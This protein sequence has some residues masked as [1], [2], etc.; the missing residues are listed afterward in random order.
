MGEAWGECVAAVSGCEEAWGEC[1]CLA[2]GVCNSAYC[3]AIDELP[4]E[5][6]DVVDGPVGHVRWVGGCSPDGFPTTTLTFGLDEPSCVSTASGPSLEITFPG[7]VPDSRNVGDE[8]VF[9]ENIELPQVESWFD[10]NGNGIS[11]DEPISGGVIRLVGPNT[12]RYEL[13]H[14]GLLV[15][16]EFSEVTPCPSQPPC[17]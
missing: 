13:F 2:G 1:S 7:E 8:R 3:A 6:V 4:F 11:D 14:G 5:L 17:G 16:G 12:G 10:A 15:Q 9:G